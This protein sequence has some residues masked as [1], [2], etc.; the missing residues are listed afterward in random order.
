MKCPKEGIWEVEN[1]FPL[2]FK[3]ATHS[4]KCWEWEVWKQEGVV[5]Q[6]SSLGSLLLHKCI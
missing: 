3:A 5:E 4:E 2:K 6:E 1:F